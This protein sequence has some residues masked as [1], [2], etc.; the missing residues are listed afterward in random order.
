MKSLQFPVL[1]GPPLHWF[2]LLQKW[3]FPETYPQG[4]LAELISPIMGCLDPGCIQIPVTRDRIHFTKAHF[5]AGQGKCSWKGKTERKWEGSLGS[6]WKP[7]PIKAWGQLGMSLKARLQLWVRMGMRSGATGRQG[8]L[9]ACSPLWTLS[10]PEATWGQE[11]D[12]WKVH[13]TSP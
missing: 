11:V 4:S 13:V 2:Q 7:C 8:V 10:W 5:P 12:F 6:P 9:R 3:S 1:S